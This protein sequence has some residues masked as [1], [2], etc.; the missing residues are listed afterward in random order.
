MAKLNLRD[1]SIAYAGATVTSLTT[2]AVGSY[3]WSKFGYDVDYSLTISATWLLTVGVPSTI[4]AAETLRRKLG[5]HQPTTVS[6][7]GG[8]RSWGRSIPVNA[9]GKASHLFL[10][11]IPWLAQPEPA[12]ELL[13]SVF[14]V[15][16]DDSSYSVSLP[17]IEEFLRTGWKRQ[18][19]GETA[20]SRPYWTRQ[21]RP[22]LNRLE[23][24]TRLSILLSVPN[25]ILDRSQRRSGRLAVPP[26]A[27]V[28][29]LQGQFALG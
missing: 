24:E 27:A 18:R 16:I 17:E 20:F 11:S 3:V 23:Y 2:A 12:A 21:H 5:E 29:A 15:K 14:T 25:L 7:A 4:V 19:R 28:K 10:S 1:I 6:A 8:G 9:N 13:P 26:M 22:R